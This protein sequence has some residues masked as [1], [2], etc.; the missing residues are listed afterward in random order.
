M[1]DLN[2]YITILVLIFIAGSVTSFLRYS[3]CTIVAKRM[4][5]RIGI[6]LYSSILDQE[7]AFFDKN[8]SGKLISRLGSDTML[9]QVVM[10]QRLPEAV[11]SITSFL[12]YSI[13]TIVAIRMVAQIGIELYASIL[14]NKTG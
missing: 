9:L 14:K 6:E 2:E 7:I 12:R 11:A 1:N 10:S 3:I 8:K 4:V 13:F 5:A